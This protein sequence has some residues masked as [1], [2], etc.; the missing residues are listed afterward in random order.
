MLLQATYNNKIYLVGGFLDNKV[1]SS[2]LFVYDPSQDKWFAGKDMPTARGAL[3]AQFIDGVF[4]VIGGTSNKPLNTNEAFDPRT[5]TWT[6]KA[7]M[8]TARQ[9]LASAVV[10]GKFYAIGG[11]PTGKSSNLDN[12]EAYDP[13]TNSWSKL[14]AMPT[15]RAA[16]L[17]LWSMEKSM[18]LEEK[19]QTRRSIIM[20]CIIR[21]LINGSKNY[22]CRRLAT[23]WQL[24]RW[25]I[26]FM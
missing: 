23:V 9:H 11:R 25:E 24:R 6:E 19:L 4:Y 20:R 10:D 8:P 18:F 16:L 17:H 3:A 13:K 22:P 26:T 2:R 5:D 1:P 12:N 14:A 21:R 15:K 7:P